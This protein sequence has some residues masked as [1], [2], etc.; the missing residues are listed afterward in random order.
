[1]RC[2]C[3]GHWTKN[4]VRW[5]VLLE[6]GK[7]FC[8]DCRCKWRSKAFY[9]RILPTWEHRDQSGVVDHDILQLILQDE[10]YVDTNKP[11]VWK[12]GKVLTIFSRTH[13][14]GPQRGT[15][16]FVQICCNGKKKKIALHRLVWMAHTKQLIP[17]GYHVDHVIDQNDDSIGN[18]QLLPYDE[19]L[20]KARGDIYVRL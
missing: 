5:V 12:N 4:I 7:V 19:N 15:Y 16:R 13:K 20:A 14:D 11:T 6:N 3:P 1:M 17:D 2:R 10:L 18:L 9:T 8:K